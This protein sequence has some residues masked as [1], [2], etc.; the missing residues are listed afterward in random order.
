MLKVCIL[1]AGV[2]SR[3]KYCKSLNKAILPIDNRA[4]ISLIME[5]FPNDTEFH[6]SLGHN[7]QSLIN[8][9]SIAENN[10]KITYT[11][12]D[13]Y[14]DSGSG[15]GLSLLCCKDHLQQPFVFT[16]CDT[17]IEEKIDNV[18]ENWVGVSKVKYPDDYLTF[19]IN[20]YI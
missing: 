1:A 7:S 2:G 10:R 14:K 6:I 9:L 20:W 8:Y 18:N 4:A 12:I 13:N 16:S 3:N 17:L 5:K 11:Y 19:G 15:P